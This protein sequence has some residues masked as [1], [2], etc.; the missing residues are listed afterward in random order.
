MSDAF[1]NKYFYVLKR[2]FL[3]LLFYSFGGFLLERIINVVFLGYWYDNSVLL[4]PYQPLYG[5]GVLLTII[6]VDVVYVRMKRIKGIYKEII[7]IIMAILFTGLVEAITGYG[8]EY[9]FGLHLWDYGNTFPCR[10]EYIC[11]Y[12][13]SLFGVISYLVVKSGYRIIY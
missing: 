2:Y 7:L 13:T 5:S 8:F 3:Y 6:F 1:K 4:G 12:P 10:L 11:I 9:F